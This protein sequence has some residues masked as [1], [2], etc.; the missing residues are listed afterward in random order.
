[1]G[2][3]RREEQKVKTGDRSLVEAMEMSQILRYIY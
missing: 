2:N 3:I 1:M